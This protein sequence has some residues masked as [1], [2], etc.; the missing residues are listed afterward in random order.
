MTSSLIASSMTRTVPSQVPSGGQ[1]L[2]SAKD[3]LPNEGY[4]S[5]AAAAGCRLVVGRSIEMLE[6]TIQTSSAR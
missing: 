4:A 6:P 2:G 5:S 3:L 1:D